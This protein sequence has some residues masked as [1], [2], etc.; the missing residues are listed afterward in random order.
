[1]NI[2]GQYESLFVIESIPD[3]ILLETL[4]K[5]N[6]YID[7]ITNEFELYV[8]AVKNENGDDY[9]ISSDNIN[10]KIYKM[11]N[12]NIPDWYAGGAPRPWCHFY[13]HDGSIYTID[14][15]IME[16]L[17]ST[18]V[19]NQVNKRTDIKKTIPSSLITY[20]D[21]PWSKTFWNN[22]GP[23]EVL[24]YYLSLD[25]TDDNESD[26]N[27][28]KNKFIEQIKCMKKLLDL[29]V[30]CITDEYI[31]YVLQSMNVCMIEL[32]TS[33]EQINEKINNK[34]WINVAK[35]YV[36]KNNSE[37]CYLF[38]Y[39]LKYLHEEESTDIHYCSNS[40]DLA[41]MYITNEEYYSNLKN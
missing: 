36:E 37:C 38:L 33:Y 40:I 4:S 31:L 20:C 13:E 23:E 9:I 27:L 6:S 18:V 19:N 7:A 22:K 12:G 26:A 15:N 11:K 10:D 24:E 30:N 29:T 17:C 34:T 5:Y 39:N 1:M 25:W 35:Q 21:R 32:L 2:F 16:D 3:G 8:K 41:K 14:P 28:I